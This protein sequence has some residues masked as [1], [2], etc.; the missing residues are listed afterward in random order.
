M[1]VSKKSRCWWFVQL[2]ENLP[3]DWRTQLHELMIPGAYIVHDRDTV[4]GDEG[5]EKPKK[6]HVHCI[7]EFRERCSG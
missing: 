7:L 3:A 1:A 2:L 5:V 4:I 6:P